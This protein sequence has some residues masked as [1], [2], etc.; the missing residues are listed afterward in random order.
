MAKRTVV[1]TETFVKAVVSA[2]QSGKTVED[3]ANELGLKL[4]SVQTRISNFNKGAREAKARELPKLKRRPGGGGGRKL[5]FA[6]LSALIPE[7]EAS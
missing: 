2:S 5:D 4:G 3:V 7:T 6:A 1:A